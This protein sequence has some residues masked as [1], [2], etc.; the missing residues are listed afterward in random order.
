MIA[1]GG[2]EMYA[3]AFKNMGLKRWRARLVCMR[4][5]P[6]KSIQMRIIFIQ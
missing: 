3:H 2:S 5:V 1:F 6:G 4:V